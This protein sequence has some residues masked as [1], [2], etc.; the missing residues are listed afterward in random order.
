M[1]LHLH[2]HFKGPL[3]T[4]GKLYIDGEYFCDTLEDTVRVE[5]I[6]HETAIPTGTYE[7]IINESPKYKKMMPL[8]V[9]VPGFEGIRI[10]TG[11]TRKDTSGCILVGVNSQKGKVLRSREKYNDLM[12][13]LS[14][15]LYVKQT[16][17][18]TIT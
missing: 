14:G 13:I 4:I 3:Y 1:E 8:L 11:N 10:H 5:K 12:Y 2:R 15:A 7:I 18:I 16:I 17:T 6:K 9:R